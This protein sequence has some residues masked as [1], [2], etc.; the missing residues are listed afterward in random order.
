MNQEDKD[1]SSVDKEK[2]KVVTDG[3]SIKEDVVVVLKRVDQ[4]LDKAKER[5]KEVE[6]L[7]QERK[8]DEEALK[9]IRRRY[10]IIT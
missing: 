4:L 8:K 3:V 10:N 7:E 2:K 9:E 5:E 1:Q 6:T